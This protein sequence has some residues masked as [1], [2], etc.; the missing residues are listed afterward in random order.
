VS[1]GTDDKDINVQFSDAHKNLVGVES[2]SPSREGH[3]LNDF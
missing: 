2:E 1:D 3:L